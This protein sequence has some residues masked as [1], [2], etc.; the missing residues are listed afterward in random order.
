MSWISLTAD[1][2][3]TRLAGPELDAVR[4]AALATGQA[5]P[6]PEIVAAVV[7]EVRGY[8]AACP[9]NRLGATG[10]LP[11]ALEAS[12]LALCRGR[13]LSRLPVPSLDTEA[14]RRE[15]EDAQKLLRDVA[16]GR[17]YVDQPASDVAPDTAYS[18]PPRPRI[19]PRPRRP[20]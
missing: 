12:A 18:P 13:L 2:V 5:D 8:V 6:L 17:F 15:V 20:L 7:E 3:A 19:T 4:S 14:R 10:T 9:R 16:A 1:S 11:K